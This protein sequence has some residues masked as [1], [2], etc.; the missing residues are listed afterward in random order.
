MSLIVLPGV[1][2]PSTDPVVLA[3][4]VASG[5]LV[6]DAPICQRCGVKACFENPVGV[7]FRE[8]WDPHSRKWGA[9]TLDA[10]CA[11]CREFLRSR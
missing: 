1:H 6:P 11:R 7:Q 2:A 3:E 10:L 5:D 9:R 4:R 8:S